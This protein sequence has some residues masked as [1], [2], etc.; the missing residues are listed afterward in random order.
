VSGKITPEAFKLGR[1]G[2]KEPQP[3]SHRRAVTPRF[4]RDQAELSR[5]SA[6][7][8]AVAARTRRGILPGGGARH[9]LVA[10]AVDVGRWS[11]IMTK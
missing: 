9:L 6:L 1:K 8:S 11:S 5:R 3:A 2:R 7:P 10:N 4:I